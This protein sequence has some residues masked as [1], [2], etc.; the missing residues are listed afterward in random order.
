MSPFTQWAAQS[1]NDNPPV[2]LEDEPRVNGYYDAQ[3]RKQ[4]YFIVYGKDIES[5]GYPDNGKIEEGAYKDDRKIGEWI[6]YH[7]DGKTPRCIGTFADGRPN[8]PYEKFNAAGTITESGTYNN[9]KQTGE[10]IVYHENGIIA[11]RKFFNAEGKMEGT[12]QYFHDNGQLEFEFNAVNGIASGVATRYTSDG[13]VKE[14]IVYSG[15]GAPVVNASGVV[16]I[17]KE[18]NE[19]VGVGAIPDNDSMLKLDGT[20]F[21]PNDYNKLYNQ[22]KALYM[23]GLF[24]EGKLWDGKLYRYDE[25]GLLLKIEIWKEGSYHSDG[26]L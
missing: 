11:Q 12:Q 7:L 19:V 6:M 13:Q 25:N 2:A 16:E 22:D 23:D 26:H 18:S 4:G 24:K 9:K 8:G 1:N 5:S 15:T 14:T 21:K 10:F 17:P 3:G 20:S